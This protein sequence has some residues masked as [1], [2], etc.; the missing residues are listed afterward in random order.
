M[1]RDQYVVWITTRR[2]KP[3]TYEEFRHAWR[4]KE[5]PQGMLRAE[6]GVDSL[7]AGGI[8]VFQPRIEIERHDRSGI[9][10][11][12]GLGFVEPLE[13]ALSERGIVKLQR[14]GLERFLPAMFATSHST[15]PA[16]TSSSGPP[17]RR[18]ETTISRSRATSGRSRWGSRPRWSTSSR[19]AWWM[20][21]ISW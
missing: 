7:N 19:T 1:D 20:P 9:L 2:I 4:P 5:F 6:V 12:Q 8:V 17:I 21:P 13:A 3:G 15:W 11:E 16:P 14:F 18:P 10:D